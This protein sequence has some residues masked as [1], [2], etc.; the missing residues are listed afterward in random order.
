MDTYST[1]EH[2]NSNDVEE[3]SYTV[4]LDQ[5]E[6][7]EEKANENEAESA[8]VTVSDQTAMLPQAKEDLN[9]WNQNVNI[10]CFCEIL[11]TMIGQLS[12]QP[13]YIYIFFSNHFRYSISCY[14]CRLTI[15]EK[16]I[17][18]YFYPVVKTLFPQTLYLW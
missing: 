7:S 1:S 4:P 18:G 8:I 12:W 9:L 17:E 2:Q 15:T 6:T 14:L 16:R 11:E 5:A 3:K 10:L 13:C